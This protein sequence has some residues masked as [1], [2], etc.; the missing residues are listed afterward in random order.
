MASV[1]GQVL[2]PG[3]EFSFNKTVGPRKTERGYKTAKIIVDGEFVEGVGGGVCQVSTTIYNA[4]LLSD[5]AVVHAI[6]HSL[7]ISYVP[8]SRDAM[9]TSV[10]DFVFRNDTDYPVYIFTSTENNLAEVSI[11]GKRLDCKVILKTEVIKSIPYKNVLLGGEELTDTEDCEKIK[12]GKNGLVS[13][14]YI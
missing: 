5:L 4:V 10:N 6:H 9:V 1:N 13:E 14:L 3:E 2:A 7:P 12:S 11:Y 8:P